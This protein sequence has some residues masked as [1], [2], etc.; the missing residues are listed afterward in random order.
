MRNDNADAP[1]NAETPDN[2]VEP[3]T[4]E[5]GGD[6]GNTGYCTGCVEKLAEIEEWKK[7]YDL[8]V[9]QHK[10]YKRL[11]LNST[12]QF[13]ELHSKYNDLVKTTA[14]LPKIPDG[15]ATASSEDIFTA[16]EVKYLQCMPLEKKTDCTFILSALK[17]VYKTDLTV[18]ATKTLKGTSERIEVTSSGEH[19]RHP[20]KDPM[21]PSKVSRIKS[22]FIERIAKCEISSPDFADRMKDA[23]VNKLFAAGIRNL[24]HKSN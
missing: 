13:S 22:L 21:T 1:D 8:E 15:V 24:A 5:C 20:A 11:Y 4:V 6:H 19:I 23:Y 9:Q 7:K 3:K 14:A 10:E 17:F 16:N 12:V 2:A 18:L